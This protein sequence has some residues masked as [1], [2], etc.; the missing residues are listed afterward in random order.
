M[1][2][3]KIYKNSPAFIQ[4]SLLT[5]RGFMYKILRESGA[6]RSILSELEHTQYYTDSEML[7][8]QNKKLVSIVK[9]AYENV[10]YYNSLFKKMKLLPSDIKNAE[11][12]KKLPFLTKEEVRVNVNDLIARNTKKL[13]LVKASTS[14]SCGKPITLYRDLYSIAFENAI[15]WRQRRWAGINLCDK[16]AVLRAEQIVPFERKGFPFWRYSASE[17]RLFLSSYHLRRNNVKCYV[18]ILESFRPVG[19]FAVPG[20]IYAMAR[21]IEEEKFLPLSFSV[22]AIF[23]SS[24]MLMPGYKETIERVFGGAMYDLYGSSERVAAIGMCEHRTYHVFPENG[25]IEFIPTGSGSTA[26]EIIGTGLHNYAMPLLRYRTGDLADLSSISCRCGRCFKTIKGIQG[27]IIDFMISRNGVI[28]MEGNWLLLKDVENII[29]SQI[30]QEGLEEIRV[31]F[32]PANNFSEK[33]KNKIIENAKIYLGSGAHVTFEETDSLMKEG[34]H[35]FRPFI[36]LIN[37]IR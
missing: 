25:I 24:D 10:P 12:L 32:V 26:M 11:D 9:H 18:D 13:L 35:K 3:N 31:K 8:W 16:T 28:L 22:K 37:N 36:S 34:V 30:V 14:G 17:K 6:F 5:A 33:D 1:L 21:F 19:I 23:T 2:K 29:E 15:L 7:E 27:R 20:F 4:N